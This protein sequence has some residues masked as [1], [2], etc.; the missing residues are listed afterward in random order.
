MHC[1][2]RSLFLVIPLFF[3]LAQPNI[4]NLESFLLDIADPTSPNYGRHWT[5]VRVTKT[6]RPTAETVETVRAWLAHETGLDPAHARLSEGGGYLNLEVTV[7]QAE[8]LLG[9]EYWVYQHRDGGLHIACEEK[10]HLPEHLVKHID[11]IWPTIQFDVRP[12]PLAPTALRVND[13][14]VSVSSHG[15]FCCTWG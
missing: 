7:E 12:A 6:F 8:A 5:P 1:K 10:Y 13:K 9:T 4:D 2:I 15:F 14:S 11:T 3:A